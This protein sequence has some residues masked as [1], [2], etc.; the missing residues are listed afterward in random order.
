MKV[1][2]IEDDP[3]TQENLRDILELDGTAVDAALSVQ[4]ALGR[5]DWSQYTAILL[6]RKL[7]DGS[8]EDLL[9]QIVQLAPEAAV[10]MVTGDAEMDL[11]IEAL[12][13]GVSDFLLKPID[14][15]ALRASLIRVEKLKQ[16][17]KRALQSERLAAIGQV[18]A[19]LTH[20]SR[21]VFQRLQANL[22]MLQDEIPDRPTALALADRALKAQADLHRLFEDV[23]EYARPMQLEL[24]VVDLGHLFRS[25]WISIAAQFPHR[26]IRVTSETNHVDLKCRADPYRLQQVFRNLLENAVAA[27]LD[28]IELTVDWTPVLLGAQSALRFNFRDNGPGLSIEA[29][30]RLFEPFFT[31]K[32]QGTGLGMS[33]AKRIVESHGGRIV[34]AN[35]PAGAEFVVTLPRKL[36]E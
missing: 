34:A 8:A 3:H 17:Q 29:Q 31:T 27:C 6:D 20:E 2:V 12:R 36:T 30:E 35:G 5:S 18:I 11:T 7:P 25:A 24:E 23:R 32:S 28:P 9:P 26:E 19:I 10:I 22:E 13:K 16:A 1:L 33:I 21:N 14:P 4:E 15:C